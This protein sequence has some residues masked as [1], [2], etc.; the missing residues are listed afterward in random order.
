MPPRNDDPESEDDDL[1]VPIP[2][3]EAVKVFFPHGGATI[4][5]FRREASKGR[6]ELIKIGNRSYVT[7]RA[8]ERLLELSRVKHPTAAPAQ[9]PSAVPRKKP[10]PR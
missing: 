3:R 6:L 2:L 8:F 10:K 9:S 1:D 4:S 5:T 7:R